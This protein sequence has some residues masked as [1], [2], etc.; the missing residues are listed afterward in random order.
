LSHRFGTA[1][2]SHS[3]YRVVVLT[4]SPRPLYEAKHSKNQHLRSGE[5]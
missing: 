5:L 1:Q 3:R 2:F 4:S